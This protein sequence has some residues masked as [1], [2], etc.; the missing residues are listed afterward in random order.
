MCV[1]FGRSPDMPGS[2][3]Q[4]R[5]SYFSRRRS[6]I[7]TSAPLKFASLYGAFRFRHA[8]WHHHVVLRS[9]GTVRSGLSTRAYR[10]LAAATVSR[11][12][13]T[14]W[15]VLHDTSARP[16]LVAGGRSG[17]PAPEAA[18]PSP[19]RILLRK[20][21]PAFGG[22][23]S[24]DDLAAMSGFY[25]GRAGSLIWVTESDLAGR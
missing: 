3:S 19:T 22:R 17:P 21:L 15:F 4:L 11:L 7:T 20:M 25:G 10:I 12:L 24:A 9:G 23:A 5:R 2:P 8:K 18:P 14:L 6:K 1:S 16:D 13:A